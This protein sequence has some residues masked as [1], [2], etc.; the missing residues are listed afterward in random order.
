MFIVYLVQLPGISALSEFKRKC[1]VTSK[2]GLQAELE[3]KIRVS[4]DD[5]IGTVLCNVEILTK[6]LSS[7]FAFMQFVP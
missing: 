1:L 3:T 5:A 4:H 2:E 6:W 7:S